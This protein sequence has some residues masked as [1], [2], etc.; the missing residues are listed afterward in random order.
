MV[1]L[2]KE[3]ERAYQKQKHVR[4]RQKVLDFLGGMCVCCRHSDYDVLQIDHVI[5]INLPS[6]KR[7]PACQMFFHILNGNLPKSD[8]QLL[9]ANCHMKKTVIELRNR[10]KK[11]AE[12]ESRR[13]QKNILQTH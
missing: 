1:R 5:P 9:C 10:E 7:M 8:F 4:N 12:I 6:K 3:K 13:W 2:S 11:P